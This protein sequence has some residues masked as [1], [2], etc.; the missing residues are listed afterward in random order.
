MVTF[1]MREGKHPTPT[2]SSHPVPPNGV[3]NGRKGEAPVTVTA[4]RCMLISRLSLTEGVCASPPH[5]TA[6]RIRPI[7]YISFYLIHCVHISTKNHKMYQ[8]AKNTVWRNG[9]NI[10]TR[11]RYGRNLGTTKQGFLKTIINTLRA[12]IRKKKERKRNE[13]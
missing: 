4:Q 9:T 6:T 8:K 11:L 3:G 13:N 2:S 12:L 10:K 7:H 5:L 1:H